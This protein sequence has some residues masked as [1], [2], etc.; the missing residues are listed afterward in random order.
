[1]SWMNEL[2]SWLGYSA[3]S[4]L[5][6][7]SLGTLAVRFCREPVYRIR[8]IQWT[9]VACLLVP[10]V[11]Q[12]ELLPGP[13]LPVP[14]ASASSAEV[15]A[16]IQAGTS[17]SMATRIAI[18]PGNKVFPRAADDWHLDARQLPSEAPLEDAAATPVSAA[19]IQHA[20]EDSTS[21]TSGVPG[22]VAS[23]AAVLPAS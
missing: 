13:A 19:T 21:H 17:D 5:L 4:C 10:L 7:L 14:G 9:F 12:F 1:M 11:Q 3:I 15:S 20:A 2:G 18:E 22:S 23:L 8:I 16:N 6:I